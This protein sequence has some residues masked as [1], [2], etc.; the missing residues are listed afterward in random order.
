[1]LADG[2][3]AA[4]VEALIAAAKHR[5][6]SDRVTDTVE[7]LTGRPPGTFAQWA[8]DHAPEFR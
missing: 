1:M 2:R 5:P 4:L 3:P 6:D 7:R 8:A